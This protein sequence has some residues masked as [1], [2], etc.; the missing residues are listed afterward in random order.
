MSPPIARLVAELAHPVRLPVLLALEEHPRSPSEL[1]EALDQPFHRV[2]HAVRALSAAGLLVTVRR[3]RSTSAPNVY[4]R[5]YATRHNGWARLVGVL[6]EVAATDA[7]D[8]ASPA[9]S[10]PGP[11]AR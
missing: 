7:G 4:R 3:E 11:T 5:V 6:G 1:A 10:G 2:N 8:D 9:R